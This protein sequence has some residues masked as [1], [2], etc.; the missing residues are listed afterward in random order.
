M[1]D[2]RI[3]EIWRLEYWN[4]DWGLLFRI[5]IYIGWIIVLWFNPTFGLI[6]K[7]DQ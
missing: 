1:L 7:G 6:T 5:L 4:Y 3:V 2:G